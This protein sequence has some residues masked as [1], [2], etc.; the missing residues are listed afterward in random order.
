MALPLSDDGKQFSRMNAF[1]AFF[2]VYGCFIC[3]GL[4]I[5]LAWTYF[6]NG[7]PHT[8]IFV[9]AALAGLSTA[10]RTIW[11]HEEWVAPPAIGV[12]TDGHSQQPIVGVVVCR[13]EP[14]N[15]AAKAITD[16]NGVFEF[17]G[18]HAVRWSRERSQ[19]TVAYRVE[20]AGFHNYWT[21]RSSDVW[22]FAK[23]Y[24]DEIG[25]IELEPK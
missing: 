2:L 3:T 5:L 13:V 22:S 1:A 12:V 9:I 23:D 17:G 11:Q 10:L 24:R 21:L 14:A 15:A 4:S 8:G 19:P 20:V 25:K 16:S 7:R 18:I 6:R